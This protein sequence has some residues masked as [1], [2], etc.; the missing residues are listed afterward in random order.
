M[1]LHAFLTVFQLSWILHLNIHRRLQGHC[2]PSVCVTH[3]TI[4][5]L[6][7]SKDLHHNQGWD[8]YFQVSNTYY[9]TSTTLLDI[10]KGFNHKVVWPAY[11]SLWVYATILTCVFPLWKI[12]MF[13]S[14][15][16]SYHLR[17]S[18]IACL[19]IFQKSQTQLLSFP[20]QSKLKI[21]S[22]SHGERLWVFNAEQSIYTAH[23]VSGGLICL[24]CGCWNHW[25]WYCAYSHTVFPS[26]VWSTCCNRPKKCHC[27]AHS[28]H[29]E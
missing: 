8:S 10:G 28:V 22:V 6:V 20:L 21:I 29:W 24:L 5:S 7:R 17:F 13:L 18:V 14:L 25:Y 26:G 2:W 12:I 4:L 1:Y 16:P 9:P 15:C 3:P 19:F 27:T 23:C 11:V